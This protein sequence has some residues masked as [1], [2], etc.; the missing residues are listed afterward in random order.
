MKYFNPL[1]INLPVLVLS[2]WAIH[3]K[4]LCSVG[5]SQNG[6]DY[7][8]EEPV[9]NEPGTVIDSFTIFTSD[10]LTTSLSYYLN[11]TGDVRIE[12]FDLFERRISTLAEGVKEQGNHTVQWVAKDES[13]HILK[14][15]P[16][17]ARIFTGNINRVATLML[18][19]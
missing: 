19:D 16:F 7:T 2:D 11:Q 18:S 13:G 12:I 4:F 10:S 8:K 3:G 9:C 15:G 17:L 14:G 6:S 5:T 1:H